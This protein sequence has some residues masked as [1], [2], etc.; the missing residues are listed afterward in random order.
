MSSYSVFLTD[1]CNLSCSY[2]ALGNKKVGRMSLETGIAAIDYALRNGGRQPE[3]CF[4]GT[5]VLLEWSLAQKLIVYA[6]RRFDEL[7]GQNNGPEKLH[8]SLTTNGL[9]LDEG[10]MAFL[11]ENGVDLS[12]S[13]DGNEQTHNTHRL[14]PN[15][16]P[17]YQR[18]ASLFP[19]LLKYRPLVT[20]ASTFTPHTVANLYV[21]LRDLYSQGFRRMTFSLNRDDPGWH[22]EHFDI[23]ASQVEQ[24]ALWYARL[25]MAGDSELRL[26]YLDLVMEG[27]LNATTGH[28]GFGEYQ[29]AVGTDGS[30]YPCWRLYG[31]PDLRLGDVRRGPDQ[32]QLSKLRLFDFKDL[33]ECADCSV[34]PY[35]LRC[36]WLNLIEGGSVHNLAKRNCQEKKATVRAAL[37]ARD[38]LLEARSPVYMARINTEGWESLGDDGASGY[39]YVRQG[40]RLFRLPDEIAEQ[41]LIRH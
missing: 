39:V 16:K 32:S 38:M 23:Y 28:C 26:G 4:F 17:T 20:I 8:L 25:L 12:V 19:L 31:W 2:C 15:G 3:I 37:M 1:N 11:E 40:D 21:G 30:F 13:I 24:V 18:L 9:L 22:V 10:K 14:L 29:L 33:K 35:C 36:P 7:T 5:E 27:S 41:Y 6:R 34:S